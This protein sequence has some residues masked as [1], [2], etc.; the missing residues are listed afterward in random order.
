VVVEDEA[1]RHFKNW[2]IYSHVEVDCATI[3]LFSPKILKI[4]FYS[5]QAQYED[6]IELLRPPMLKIGGT[7][8]EEA[9][10][11]IVQQDTTSNPQKLIC[12]GIFE[13]NFGDKE[14]HNYLLKKK[15]KKTRNDKDRE[16]FYISV[17]E[18][19]HE[20]EQY[21]GAKSVSK[22]AETR[23]LYKHQKEFLTKILSGWEQW[24]E[25]LLF[26]KCR[27]GK[28]TMVL[29]AIVKSGV[30]MTLVVSRFKSPEQSWRE[31]C[32]LKNFEDLVFIDVQKKNYKEEIKKYLLTKKQI[33]VWGTVQSKSKLMDLP[34]NVD[35]IVYDEAHEGYGSKQW[36]ELSGFH[37][38][39]VLY[40]TGTAYNI[41]ENFSNNKFVYSYFEEQ[42]DK[43]L[44]L[45]AAPSMELILV[46]YDL[47]EEYKKLYGDAPD[48]MS[49]LF[50][51]NGD[52]TNFREFSLVRGFYSEY[53]GKK[54]NLIVNQ[55]L[56][57]KAKHIYM[58]LPSIA[59]CH[60][61][62]DYLKGT[63]FAP[64]VV[65]GDTKEDSDS[66]KKH[67]AENPQGTI[68]LTVRANVLGVTIEELDTVINCAEGDSKNFYFQFAFR[69]GSSKKNWTVIDFC[70]RRC[71]QTLR[72][73]YL[74]SCDND[75]SISEYEFSEYF[76]AIFEYSDGYTVMSQER[77]AEILSSNDV[78]NS[79]RIM[80]RVAYS[81]DFDKLEDFVMDLDLI[82]TDHK[83]S[84]SEVISSADVNG[85]SNKTKVNHNP[86]YKNQDFNVN[87]NKKIK[88]VEAILERIPLVLFHMIR[89][90]EIPNSIY[91]VISSDHY[92]ND[93]LDKENVLRSLLDEKIINE[94][95]LNCRMMQV[96]TDIQH[97]IVEDECGT[98]EK[99]SCSRQSQKSIPVELMDQL[100]DGFF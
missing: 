18:A 1:L 12:K 68:I 74:S 24:K 71:L 77:L 44:G 50:S 4:Y 21:K 38:C 94:R 41:E 79:R 13:T 10:I 97:Q 98:L 78:E 25:F 31:D 9:K 30:K 37:N 75:P 76:A 86:N 22:V 72:E 58:C 40:V 35:L 39:K 2:H 84:K 34:C 85:K 100:L 65:T 5:T 16:W 83:K 32:N 48:A 56:L 19:N 11:R 96:A 70:P 42:R 92:V 6:Q 64:L 87:L 29:S 14:F 23:E 33:I 73:I 49:N 53:F 51:L 62:V 20:L 90:S 69:G 59:A 3:I 43:K 81:M 45:N 80:S 67:I 55:R 99:L 15:Y 66:I 28:S 57:K 52:K 8:L 89:K 82:P 91:H 88:T 7:S 54:K 47:N 61:S 93:T 60:L 27:S 36:N 46:Q 26:A 95:S 63:D 17:E